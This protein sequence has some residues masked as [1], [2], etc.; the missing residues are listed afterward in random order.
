MFNAK[1]KEDG[2]DTSSDDDSS[3]EDAN[4][5]DNDDDD[6]DDDD[7]TKDTEGNTNDTP[8]ILNI[9]REN[10]KSTKKPGIEMLEDKPKDT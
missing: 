6:N 2:D 3:S 10:K 1:V 5:D 8:S 4:D 9:A 7:T